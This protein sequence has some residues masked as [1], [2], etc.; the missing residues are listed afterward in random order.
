MTF[1]E[2]AAEQVATSGGLLGA[3]GTVLGTA[4][5]VAL[6]LAARW[7][8][9]R[10]DELLGKTEKVREHVANDHKTNLRNDVDGLGS[11]LDA[12]LAGVA[13]MRR[14]IGGLREENRQ[15]RAELEGVRG[16]VRRVQ[17]TA[18]S[19]RRE[20]ATASRRLRDLDPAYPPPDGD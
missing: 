4:A 6:G 16:D 20:A 15:Q 2:Q 14:D 7:L 1:M 12:V 18:E 19:A 13:E 11:K 3:L 17:D 10:L 9:P 8:K 5:V